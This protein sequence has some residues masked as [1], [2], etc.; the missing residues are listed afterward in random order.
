MS[1]RPLQNNL[2]DLICAPATA[3]V[4]SAVAIVRLSGQGAWLVAQKVAPSVTK[5]ESHRAYLSRLVS[6]D[7]EWI[8]QG[9]V[10][11]FAEGRSYTGQESVEF[12]THGNPVIVEK[13]MDTLCHLGARRAEPGEFTKRAFLNGRLDL[14][15][16][17]SVQSLVQSKSWEQVQSA[18]SSLIG[19]RSKELS[20]VED[21]LIRALAHLEAD[22]DFSTEGLSTAQYDLLLRWVRQAKEWLDHVVAAA[23]STLKRREGFHVIILGLPNAGKSS[24]LNNILGET[25]AIVTPIP[26]TTRDIIQA[27]LWL[28]GAKIVFHDTA[29]IREVADQ[30]EQ[31]GIELAKA[32]AQEVDLVFVVEHPASA[33]SELESLHRFVETLQAPKVKIMTHQ[34]EYPSIRVQ[35]LPPFLDTLL[36]NNKDA[37]ATQ[38]A[39]HQWLLKYLGL[40]YDWEKSFSLHRIQIDRLKKAVDRLQQSIS[41]LVQGLSQEIVSLSLREALHEIMLVLGRHYDDQIVDQIFAE[42]CLGK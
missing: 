34:D 31:M 41:E 3:L 30:V 13:L 1:L 7:A 12:Y 20:R 40:E 19:E 9:L 26:G 15:Q 32:R 21:L 18:I 25:R 36:V 22:I 23:S 10:L 5:P 17:Q 37:M 27:E 2:D 39:I 28:K 6:G 38:M 33:L 29:G 35:N 16:A 14:V 24:L 42:F 11:F 4:Q 8:D